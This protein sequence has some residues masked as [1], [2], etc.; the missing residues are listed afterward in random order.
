MITPSPNGENGGR[1]AAGRFTKG[2]PGGPG[3][4]MGR[5]VAALRRALLD[6]VTEEDVRALAGALLEKAKGGDVAA[7]RLIMPYLVG[8]PPDLDAEVEARLEQL[9]ALLAPGEAAA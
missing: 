6:A 5:R 1:D 3:N 4:P 2:N 8:P 9:E 7:A